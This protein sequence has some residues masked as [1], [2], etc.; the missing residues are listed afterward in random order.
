M[1][2]RQPSSLRL[3]SVA[4]LPSDHAVSVYCRGRQLPDVA[5]NHLYFTDTW[6]SWIEDMGWERPAAHEDHGPRLVIPWYD[7]RRTLLGA[8][9]RRIDATGH[10]GR[11]ITVKCHA[12]APKVYGLDR[13]D[14]T[15][16]VHVVEG[17]MDSWFLPNCIAAMGSDLLRVGDTYLSTHAAVYVWDNEPRN[18]MVVKSIERAIIQNRSVVVWPT[19]VDAH[20]DLN[21]MALAGLDVRALVANHTYRGL[22]AQLEF[23]RWSKRIR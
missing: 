3:P 19:F 21:D 14:L 23:M 17:P 15:H 18:L 13:M 12:D 20:K 10:E 4:S 8:Q 6:L 5:L 2:A 22:R 1:F 9:F 16:V 7:R 11:Y